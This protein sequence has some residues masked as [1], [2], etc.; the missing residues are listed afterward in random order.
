MRSFQLVPL[1][2][3]VM[4]VLS[5]AAGEKG[6]DLAYEID[7]EATGELLRSA[8]LRSDPQRLQQVFMNLLSNAIKVRATSP[9]SL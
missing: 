9:R 7:G 6:L 5:S 1:V 3:M 4:E 8:W 2:E